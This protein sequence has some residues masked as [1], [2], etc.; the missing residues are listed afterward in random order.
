MFKWLFL[1]YSTNITTSSIDFKVN[2]W[3]YINAKIFKIKVS[4]YLIFF[5][6]TLNNLYLKTLKIFYKNLTFELLYIKNIYIL[7]FFVFLFSC[8]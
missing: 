8:I 3:L 7:I 1:Y 4:N 2:I 5:I 6:L